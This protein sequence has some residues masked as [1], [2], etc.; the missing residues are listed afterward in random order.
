MLKFYVP[1]MYILDF[2]DKFCMDTEVSLTTLT[3]NSVLLS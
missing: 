2:I 1:S 3:Y